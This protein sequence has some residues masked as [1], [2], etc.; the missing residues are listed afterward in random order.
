M[1]DINASDLA[2]FRREVRDFVQANLTPEMRDRV[3]QG[4]HATKQDMADWNRILH[5]RG[6]SAPHWPVEHGGT[7]WSALQR[8]VFDIEMA[9][10]DAPELSPFGLFLIGPVLHR[11][12]SDDQKRRYLPG[13]LD[14]STFWCQ[15]YSEPNAGS[16]LASLR[17]RAVRD[18]DHYVVN[19]Q[20]IWTSEAHYADMIFC[21]VRTDT[22]AKAQAG[23]TMLLIDMNTPGITVR[24]IITQDMARY[25]NEVFFE[26]VRVPVENRVGDENKGWT[27]AKFLLENERTASAYLPQSKRDLKRLKAIAGRMAAEEGDGPLIDDPAFDAEIA[28]AEI[29]LTAHEMMIWRVLSDA[30]GIDSAAAASMIKIRGAELRQRISALWIEALGPHALPLYG[31]KADSNTGFGE[32][33]APGAM[34]QFLIRRAVSIYGGT[35][36]IQHEI[37][38][39]RGLRL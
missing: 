3:R 31:P 5:G 27:Y 33:D 6:W 14:G 17:T 19:G 38:A 16:D 15:G 21:L 10:G 9:D 24:P 2:A 20:K 12:G 13:I 26:D 11:F 8:M 35:N 30:T 37:I 28:R 4:F 32:P 7:G 22:G 39:K 1:D 29:D 18:G 36:E 23:I 34:S 25:V